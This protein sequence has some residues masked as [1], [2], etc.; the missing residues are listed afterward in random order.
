MTEYT[1]IPSPGRSATCT[2][3]L[4][5][6]NGTETTLLHDVLQLEGEQQHKITK[7]TINFHP[8]RGCLYHN[9]WGRLQ[10]PLDKN[11]IYNILN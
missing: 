3:Q 5:A 1:S 2:R 4:G 9:L 8:L 11:T 6:D 7:H 10:T